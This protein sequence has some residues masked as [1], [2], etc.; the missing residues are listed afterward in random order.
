[1]GVKDRLAKRDE[2]R[3]AQRNKVI[4]LCVDTENCLEVLKEEKIPS[5]LALKCMY[6]LIKILLKQRGMR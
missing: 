4:S 3:A 2:A 5:Y 1:M 6:G